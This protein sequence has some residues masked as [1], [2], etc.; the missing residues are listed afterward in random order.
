M[1]DDFRRLV[2]ST[3]LKKRELQ[4]IARVIARAVTLGFEGYR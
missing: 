2:T 1:V 4:A 3:L